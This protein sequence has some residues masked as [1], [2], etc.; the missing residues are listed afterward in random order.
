[1]NL[2]A[3]SGDGERVFPDADIIEQRLRVV[4]DLPWTISATVLLDMRDEDLDWLSVAR[5]RDSY[6]HT[7]NGVVKR[8][9]DQQ[10]ARNPWE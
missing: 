7:L 2:T 1:M 9:E 10:K 3:R 4:A 8:I 6:W 5:D